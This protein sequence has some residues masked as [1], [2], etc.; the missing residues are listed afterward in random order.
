MKQAVTALVAL[1]LVAGTLAFAGCRPDAPLTPADLD[2]AAADAAGGRVLI[3]RAWSDGV[4]WELVKP[5]PPGIGASDDVRVRAYQIAPVAAGD[6]L[7]PPLSIPGLIEVAGRD[8]VMQAPRGNRGS[9]TAVARTVPVLVPGWQPAPPFGPAQCALPD[10]GPLAGRIAWQWS[11]P[12]PHPC[13]RAPQVFA[14]QL[15]GEP[16]VRPLTSV[17]RVEAA[18]R[19]GLVQFAFP[20]EPAWPYALRPITAAGTGRVAPAAPGCVTAG[21]RVIASP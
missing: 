15:D 1:V 2:L 4:Q 7:S 17:A 6:P 14:V 21:E 13:G 16:C 3:E 11:D 8:H 19:Q 10:L 20:P 5:R 18:E 9:Y 12:T